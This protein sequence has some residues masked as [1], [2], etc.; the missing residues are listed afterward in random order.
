MVSPSPS[1][2]EG[3]GGVTSPSPGA[4]E[5]EGMRGGGESVEAGE[6]EGAKI[7]WLARLLRSAKTTI[8]KDSFFRQLAS[9]PLT[10]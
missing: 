7:G 3:D 5:G 1:L 4:N 2:G 9:T 10:K 6:G 8:T